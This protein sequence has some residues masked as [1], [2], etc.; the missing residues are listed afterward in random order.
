[1][2]IAFQIVLLISILLFTL[3]TIGERNRRRQENYGVVCIM[4]VT[5]FIV[6]VVWL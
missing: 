1:M 3:A 6:S 5:A 4:S 2:L